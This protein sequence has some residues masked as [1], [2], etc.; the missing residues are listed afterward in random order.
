MHA[1]S[2]E[3]GCCGAPGR[4]KRTAKEAA[5]DL[6]E[7]LYAAG[8]EG[9]VENGEE[10]GE[11]EGARKTEFPADSE[12]TP[13]DAGITHHVPGGTW[14]MQVVLRVTG[15]DRSA[16]SVGALVALPDAGVRYVRD[17]CTRLPPARLLRGWGRP[18]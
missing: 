4:Q 2:E 3:E 9:T 8:N 14:L 13:K 12:K 18:C 7:P 10:S 11:A 1:N 15:Q 16:V 6:G 17:V 5:R